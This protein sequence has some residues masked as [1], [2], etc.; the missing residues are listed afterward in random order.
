MTGVRTIVLG[1]AAAMTAMTAGTA[2]AQSSAQSSAQVEVRSSV[3][4]VDPPALGKET[5]LSVAPVAR[6]GAPGAVTGAVTATA[7]GG[8]YA[9]SGVAGDTF[10]IAMP[11]S[12]RLV[13]GDGAGEVVLRLSPSGA[14]TTLP[15][16]YGARSV[17][18]VD[19]QGAV[20]VPREA[21]AGV[22]RG[23]FPVILSL[24]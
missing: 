12:L 5:E 17:G 13:R 9:V 14:M 24:Q 8:R 23:A 20:G 4:I 15:G 21:A 2:L 10:N 11:A 19:I 1:L 7:V 22:Y 18:S 16:A 3:T 6:G